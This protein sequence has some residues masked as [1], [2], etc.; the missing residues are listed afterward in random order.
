MNAYEH[1]EVN[2]Q[3]TSSMRSFLYSI[4]NPA[5]AKYCNLCSI[6]F[7]QAGFT[8]VE[9]LIIIAIAGILTSIAVPSY[10]ALFLKTGLET[11]LDKLTRTIQFSRDSALTATGS[12]RITVCPS[13]N[14]MQLNPSCLAGTETDYSDGWLVFLDCNDDE[15][16]Q[17][18]GGHC[19]GGDERLMLRQ[20]P[21]QDI[22]IISDNV[23]RIAFDRT[24]RNANPVGFDVKRNATTLAEIDMNIIGFLTVSIDEAYSYQ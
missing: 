15:L 8:L 2:N 3:S 1:F 11:A 22:D 14:P 19:S 17:D 21:L 18:T 13:A 5:L 6:S 23:S 9:L 4:A 16:Y 10:R 7:R 12:N 24:G 20:G